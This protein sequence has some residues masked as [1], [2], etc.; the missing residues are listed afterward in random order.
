MGT[1]TKNLGLYKP[2]ANDYYNVET[3]Q[4][5][6]FDKIDEKFGKVDNGLKTKLDKGSYEGDADDL[7]REIDGKE[8]AFSKNTGFN[9]EKTDNYNENDTNKLFTQKGA[10]DLYKEISKK[11]S[12]SEFGLMKVG[13]GLADDG[14]G[15]VKI[16]F[17]NSASEGGTNKVVN[18]K[19]IK[20]MN[21]SLDSIK[22]KHNPVNPDTWFIN[23]QNDEVDNVLEPGLYQ[24]FATG[25]KYHLGL[26]HVLEVYP[27]HIRQVH[28]DW[29]NG[30][31]IRD[32]YKA[33]FTGVPWVEVITTK[34]LKTRACP[35]NVGDI[36]QTTKKENPSAI[37][38]GTQWEKI[39][40]RFLYSHSTDTKT[41]GGS[42]EIV[43]TVDQL[44][45]HNHG[46]DY[47]RPLGYDGD[48]DYGVS[49]HVHPRDGGY[50]DSDYTGKGSRINIMPAYYT[51]FAWVRIA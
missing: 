10:N 14:N 17:T 41:T 12:K 13:D 33:P 48:F 2:A 38:P 15:T 28:H 23:D 9:K 47:V 3:D 24:F 7:K 25:G 40:N 32:S 50:R 34:N 4:N 49:T 35:Y 36:Y 43:L 19:H 8:P 45:A 29:Q 22:Y 44:P 42:N 6:N 1:T 30:I 31:F 11:A 51:M 5:E 18:A 20:D 16:N 39:N 27:E 21:T 46:I 37:W 26:V